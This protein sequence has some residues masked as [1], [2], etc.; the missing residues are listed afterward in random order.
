MLLFRDVIDEFRGIGKSHKGMHGQCMH[1]N[2][3]YHMGLVITLIYTGDTFARCTLCLSDFSV[4]HGGRNDV[5]THVNGKRHKEATSAASTSS[6]V[7][8]FLGHW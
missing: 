8:S 2:K 5:T 4:S 7:T 1:I 6:A 3:L